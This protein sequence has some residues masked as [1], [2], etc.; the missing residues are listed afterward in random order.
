VFY[1]EGSPVG[2]PLGGRIFEGACIGCHDWTGTGTTST[3]ASLTGTRAVND[4]TA[5]NVVQVILSGAEHSGA[6]GPVSMPA[7]AFGPAY[8]DEEIAAVANYITAR[9]GTRP[10][11]VLPTDV[12]KART[13]A[14]PSP[15]D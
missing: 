5:T 15:V 6:L 4:P 13:F 12:A 14:G 10:S 8:S 2:N 1:K 11:A 9:F 3:Y 7:F